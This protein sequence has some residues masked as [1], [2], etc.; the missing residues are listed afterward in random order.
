MERKGQMCSATQDRSAFDAIFLRKSF[1][2]STVM[3]SAA[4]YQ[5]KASGS[6]FA[7]PK[8]GVGS[9]CSQP[10]E[11]TK[12]M[13]LS[14]AHKFKAE[15]KAKKDEFQNKDAAICIGATLWSLNDKQKMTQVH[16]LRI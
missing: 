8:H 13:N 10:H 5:S 6:R 3:Q 9:T 1:T 4:H 14:K 15:R 7:T 12:F 16:T 2:C 11:S